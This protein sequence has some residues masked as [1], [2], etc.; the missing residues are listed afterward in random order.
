MTSMWMLER[1]DGTL[2]DFDKDNDPVFTETDQGFASAD[3]ELIETYRRDEGGH[4]VEMVPAKPKV[5]VSQEEAGLVE[6][7]TD[8]TSIVPASTIGSYVISHYAD[9]KD[10]SSEQ[11]R[12]MEAVIDGY[13]VVAP[14]TEPTKYNVKV[15]HLQG[16]YYYHVDDQGNI[17][18]ASDKHNGDANQQFTMEQIKHY[19]LDSCER[20][21]INTEGSDEV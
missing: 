21:E 9:A 12:L 1:A 20:V 14:V 13:E 11:F 6:D 16:R 18:P 8:D 2:L 3:K 10:W 7:I 19:G 17:L 5:P 15:P 4:L